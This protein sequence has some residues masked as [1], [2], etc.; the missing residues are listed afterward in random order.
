MIPL[1]IISEPFRPVEKIKQFNF[2][3]YSSKGKEKRKRKGKEKG[4]KERARERGRGRKKGWR[5][6]RE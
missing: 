3:L 5:R 4:E 1:N 2:K 6:G